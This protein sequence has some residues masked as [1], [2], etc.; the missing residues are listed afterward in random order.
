VRVI[1]PGHPFF[2]LRPY[3]KEP[4]VR[5]TLAS[6]ACLALS[7][8][9]SAQPLTTAFTYEGQLTSAGS[10]ASGLWDIR[11][12]L[13]DA[14]T[15]GTQLGSVYCANDVA[16]TAGRFAV[17]IDFGAQFNGPQRFLEVEA[18]PN[19]GL[20]C[21]NTTGYTI[22][23][24]RQ[25]LTATPYALYAASVPNPLS[26]SGNNTATIYSETTSTTTNATA[27]VGFASAGT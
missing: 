18:R 13:Y 24:P 16:V 2:L 8:A 9:A 17:S 6:L 3:H 14:P 21:A 25:P 4:S 15:L 7:A 5:K 19:T 20:T 12:R 10:L 1:P 26:L 23:T 27:V 11:F 22:L